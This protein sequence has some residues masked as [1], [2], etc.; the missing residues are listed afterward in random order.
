VTELPLLGG[1]T[2]AIQGCR[3]DL[4]DIWVSN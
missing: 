4:L 1:N 2:G 3:A